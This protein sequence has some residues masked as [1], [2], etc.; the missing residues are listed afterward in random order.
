MENCIPIKVTKAQDPTIVSPL[1]E[2]WVYRAETD[3]KGNVVAKNWHER[4][5][6]MS[7]FLDEKGTYK[8]HYMD[9]RGPGGFYETVYEDYGYDE[10]YPR[11]ASMSP[12]VIGAA[13]KNSNVKLIG[14]FFFR[15]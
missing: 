15:N 4:N 1:G 7:E 3:D 9:K 10:K 14:L 11:S 6:D 5:K 2:E 8:E 13:I 12:D